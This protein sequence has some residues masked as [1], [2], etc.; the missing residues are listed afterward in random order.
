MG[1]SLSKTAVRDGQ[2]LVLAVLIMI[3]ILL[4][5]SLFVAVVNYNQRA[6][7]RQAQLL[8]TMTLAKAGMAHADEMLRF[9]PQ[10]LDWRPELPPFQ[11]SDGTPGPLFWGPDDMPYT[12]DD[13]YS[14][15]EILNNWYPV[16]NPG[17]DGI[18]GTNDD[19]YIRRGFTRYPDMGGGHFLLRVTYDPDPPYEEWQEGD[20][21]YINPGS[22]RPDPLSKYLKIESIGVTEGE[23]FVSRKVQAYKPVALA[24]YLLFVSDRTRYGY[25]TILGYNPDIDMDKD[26]AL[27]SFEPAYDYDI[28]PIYTYHGPMRFNTDVQMQGLDLVSM[29]PADEG[30][31]AT[32]P[33]SAPGE[34]EGGGYLRG[35]SLGSY[36][37]VQTVLTADA[38]AGDDELHILNAQG[39]RPGDRVSIA[40]TPPYLGTV[41]DDLASDGAIPIDPAVP[42]AVTYP[43]GSP[44]QITCADVP[45]LNAPDLF[46][47]DP[48]TGTMRWNALTREA[49]LT[50]TAVAPSPLAGET[51]NTAELGWMWDE[52]G[53]QIAG[54]YIDNRD[55]LQYVDGNGVHHIN[56]LMQEWLNPQPDNGGWNAL[57]EVYNKAP[58]V[59]IELFPT[60][61][62]TREYAAIQYGCATGAV[63]FDRLTTELPVNGTNNEIW[64]P[65]HTAG[66]PGIRITRGQWSNNGTAGD[67]DG[68]GEGYW[69]LGDPNYPNRLGEKVPYDANGD[70]SADGNMRT[71]YVDYPAGGRAVIY[72]EGN[73]RIKGRLPRENVDG[74]GRQYH[75]TV[76]SGGTIYIDGQILSPQDQQGRDVDGSSPGVSDE[77]NTY[78]ALLARDCVVVN[79]TMLVPQWTDKHTSVQDQ[80]DNHPL[81][82]ADAP[83]RHWYF[84]QTN[85]SLAT[86]N[87]YQGYNSGNDI[88]LVAQ[89]TMDVS[90]ARLTSPPSGT[91]IY[92]ERPGLFNIND[93]V[94][95]KS[96]APPVGAGTWL[97]FV[98]NTPATDG[99]VVVQNAPVGYSTGDFLEITGQPWVSGVSL[100]FYDFTNGDWLT[101]YDF[102]GG[103]NE[104]IF[105]LTRRDFATDEAWRWEMAG[106]ANRIPMWCPLSSDPTPLLPWLI[107]SDINPAAGALNALMLWLPSTAAIQAEND[108]GGGPNG[109]VRDYWLKKFKLQEFDGVTPVGTIHAKIN[110]VMY[111][112]NGC[113]FVIPG[114]YFKEDVITG[115]A[116]EYLRYNYDVEI[117]GAITENFHPQPA[118]VREWQEK[119]AYPSTGATPWNSIRYV[120]D[121]TLRASRGQV[122]TELAAWRYCPNSGPALDLVKVPLLPASPDL[123]YYGEVP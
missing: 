71:M 82:P 70:G 66:Q 107:S 3:A 31:P 88:K 103:S 113:F 121:E 81:G 22:P 58:A 45:H 60:E 21:A 108:D 63:N 64:W 68:L 78:I 28:G 46:A 44:V 116:R 109:R 5:G 12:A 4:I 100:R 7:G 50:R 74:T 37:P 110:A 2:A 93:S 104:E 48:A 76:V 13:Y 91:T 118:V 92:V 69:A 73:V 67:D 117:R 79:P 86:S 102:S 19:Y 8:K 72:A 61:T 32:P 96:A 14:H 26:G 38:T 52:N 33:T 10:G 43:A 85:V 36:K 119:W 115:E 56:P 101:T 49:G 99:Y 53:T 6:S 87:F 95:I 42:A 97:G 75:L 83:D 25:P 65:R 47:W 40:G 105:L 23:G 106:A 27:D 18:P 54:L 20:P 30:S 114:R 9:S 29:T 89:Q 123:L 59:E 77:E 120:Y 34:I 24:N 57:G 35:D 16:V 11:Y 90:G 111:A 51:H 15:E 62:A 41:T 39:F 94:T 80:A 98:Q 112:Q 1:R 122:P 17:P 55:D 84:P